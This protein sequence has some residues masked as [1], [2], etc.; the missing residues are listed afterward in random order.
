ME[1]RNGCE[2]MTKPCRCSCVCSFR[3][4]AS[5]TPNLGI[6]F[7]IRPRSL[8]LTVMAVALVFSSGEKCLQGVA[9]DKLGI[10]HLGMFFVYTHPIFL[11]AVVLAGFPFCFSLSDYSLFTACAI[12]YLSFLSIITFKSCL[13]YHLGFL[14]TFEVCF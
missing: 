4:E 10:K 14:Y 11:S 13:Y 5:A 12:I 7:R 2:L 1:L 6:S 9:L 8:K 3:R